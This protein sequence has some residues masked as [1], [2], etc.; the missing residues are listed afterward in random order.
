MGLFVNPDNSQFLDSMK[1]DIYVE[2]SR[3]IEILNQRVG[4]AGRGRLCVS[5]PRRFGKSWTTHLVAAYYSRGCD[6]REVFCRLS[7]SSVDG[8]DCYLNKMNVLKLDLNTFFNEAEDPDQVVDIMTTAVLSELKAEFNE[9]L[10]GDEDSLT[11]AIVKIYSSTKVGFVVIIDEY[12]VMMRERV[13][14]SAFDKYLRFLN[15]M[16]KDSDTQ[17]AIQLAYLT[18]IIPIVRDK[19][20]SKL[21]NFTE[22]TMLSPKQMAP[23]FGF[24]REDVRAI[25]E[26]RNV[27]FAKCLEWYDG[28]KLGASVDISCPMSVVSAVEDGEFGCHWGNTGS[29][30]CL[31]DYIDMDFD[32]VRSDVLQMMDGTP[33]AVNVK[34]FQNTL[35]DFHSKDDI[36]TY[37]IHLGYLAYDAASGTAYI[38]NREVREQWEL[39]VANNPNYSHILDFVATSRAL[40]ERTIEGDEAAVAEALDSAHEE[41]T[42]PLSYNNEQS[43][44]SAITLAYFYAKADYTIVRE[45]PAGRGYADV[46]FIPVVPSPNRPAILV[47]LKWNKAVTAAMEQISL[48]RYAN[49]L[50][51]YR[52][53]IILVA[54]TYDSKTKTHVCKIEKSVR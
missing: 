54:V 26:A 49:A 11:S 13:S 42:S 28:Y 5:R 8:W 14:R 40:I 47:E 44:Q 34:S 3:I 38:P 53:N 1:S 39:A 15:R 45:M 22:F 4:T 17:M 24:T 9:I 19:V 25:C 2:K 46:A 29:F 30:D 12:D 50:A 48:K 6:S 20:G 41:V 10:S 36:F 23:C 31:K 21:N 32:G 37:L 18:G 16:F 7:L 33:V 43:L 51:H 35:T 52:G 27:D